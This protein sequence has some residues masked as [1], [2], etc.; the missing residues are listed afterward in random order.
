MSKI[1]VTELDVNDNLRNIETMAGAREHLA[2]RGR[3][4][5]RV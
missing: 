3:W 1:S 2:L 5:H 4:A